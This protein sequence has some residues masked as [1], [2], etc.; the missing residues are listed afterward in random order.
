MKELHA[1]LPDSSLLLKGVDHATSS[2][3]VQ[4][5]LLGFRVNAFRSRVSLDYNPSVSTV[6]QFV[7]LLQAEFESA[8]LS[9]EGFGHKGKDAGREAGLSRV[10]GEEG[11]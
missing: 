11:V 8:S 10:C 4:N 7:R 3:L 1:A 5:P 6:L 2:L 9:Q